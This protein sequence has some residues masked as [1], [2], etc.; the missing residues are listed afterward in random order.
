MDNFNC[1]ECLKYEKYA[2]DNYKNAVVVYLS[3]V[4]FIVEVMGNI[5]SISFP[6]KFLLDGRNLIKSAN[7]LFILL[8][9]GTWNSSRQWEFAA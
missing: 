1:T 2:V 7:S 9:G 6:C 4:E 8:K 5:T 3:Y